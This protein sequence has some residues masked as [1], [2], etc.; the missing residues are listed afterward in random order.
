[1]LPRQKTL[2]K[3]SYQWSALRPQI[4]RCKKQ[5][6]VGSSRRELGL[7][8]NWRKVTINNDDFEGGMDW[9]ET[10]GRKDTQAEDM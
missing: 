6:T 4:S 1:M 7:F 10:K 5:S 3:T 8:L 9:T 2:G